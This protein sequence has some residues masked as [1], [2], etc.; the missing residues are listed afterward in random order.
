MVKIYSQVS[1]CVSPGSLTSGTFSANPPPTSPTHPTLQLEF[2]WNCWWTLITSRV[3]F[4][5]LIMACNP[6]LLIPPCTIPSICPLQHFNLIFH[7][8]LWPTQCSSH[9]PSHLPRCVLKS[10]LCSSIFPPHT[11]TTLSWNASYLSSILLNLTWMLTPEKLRDH[12]PR[13]SFYMPQ[14][15]GLWILAVP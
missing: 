8:E 10:D 1:F 6:F 11:S 4:Y 5:F 7:R 13:M 2:V 14:F 9:S 3:E 12:L 15:Q